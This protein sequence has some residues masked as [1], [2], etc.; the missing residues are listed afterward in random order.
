MS[1]PIKLI[2]TDFDGT[3]FQEF[4]QPPIPKRV[5][6][7]IGNLQE[8]GA[9]WVI[10][11]GR[12]LPSLMQAL[13]GAGVSTLPDFLVLVER[14]IHMNE[15]SRFVGLTEWNAAC[16]RDHADLFARVRPDLPHLMGWVNTRFQARVYEDAYSPFCLIAGNNGDADVIH[17]FLNDY[18]RRVP[19]LAVVRNDVYARFSHTD[20]NKGTAL[21]ELTRRLGLKVNQVFAAGDHL[22]DLPML[23]RDLARWLA[24][25]GNAVEAVKRTVRHQKGFVSEHSH[26]DGVADALEFACQQAGREN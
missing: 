13:A 21:A 7:L 1:S 5:L 19:Q 2:S 23:S 24:A 8:R 11:T 12:D 14:E 4:G 17:D 6:T 3:L 10:N 22:N 20:Y 9:K 16:A 26:G 18:C 15:G 25:P